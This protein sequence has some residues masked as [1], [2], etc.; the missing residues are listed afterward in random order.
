MKTL[1]LRGS[2]VM[3]VAGWSGCAHAP[4]TE[5]PPA[6]AAAC[7][8]T[9]T[10]LF[11]EVGGVPSATVVG[12]DTNPTES[13][14][15]FTLDSDLRPGRSHLCWNF[16]PLS[17]T[18]PAKVEWVHIKNFSTQVVQP[19]PPFDPN[20]RRTER[21]LFTSR[22]S[23]SPIEYPKGSGKSIEGA[24]ITYEVEIKIVD[25]GPFLADPDLIIRK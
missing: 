21:L 10:I 15:L 5:G 16:V 22:P 25:G 8:Q 6:G 14:T 2:L 12:N 3:L 20:A 4:R 13:K 24:R 19:G 9:A 7:D 23:F 17:G 11:Q 1:V 18:D